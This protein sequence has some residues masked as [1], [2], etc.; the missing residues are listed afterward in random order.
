MGPRLQP[1]IQIAQ[2]EDPALGVEVHALCLVDHEH[3]SPSVFGGGPEHVLICPVVQDELQGELAGL[4]PFQLVEVAVDLGHL[5][6]L[7]RF[8]G[9]L[10]L[11]MLLRQLGTHLL[12][13][14]RMA[15]IPAQLRRKRIE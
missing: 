13:E 5:A 11:P 10:L 6:D 15:F 1:L 12:L 8:L 14:S 2:D 7:D 3:Q 9:A 4:A